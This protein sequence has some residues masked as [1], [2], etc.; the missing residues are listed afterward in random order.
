[1]MFQNGLH[2]AEEQFKNF[3]AGYNYNKNTNGKRISVGV[4]YTSGVD[5]SVLLDIASKFKDMLNYELR[6]LY[7]GYGDLLYAK[8]A[9]DIALKKAEQ[10]GCKITMQ[11]CN[12]K[13]HSPTFLDSVHEVSTN[14]LFKSEE[15]DL[16]L[17]PDTTD[18]MVETFLLRLLHGSKP[19]GLSGSTFLTT[20]NSDGNKRVIGR[21]F[22][23]IERS[24]ILDYARSNPVEFLTCEEL[25]SMESTDIT[26]IRNNIMPMINHRFNLRGFVESTTAIRALIDEVSQPELVIDVK[27]GDWSV[28]DFLNLSIGNRMFLIR[29]YFKTVHQVELPARV[30][31]DIRA[32]LQEDLTDLC[33]PIM[34]K[35]VIHKQDDRIRV[36]I[37]KEV[38][39]TV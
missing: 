35:F 14:L 30:V 18:T 23:G 26:Y 4:L 17:M 8:E 13:S 10:Y 15:L 19:A 22:L 7:L 9:D 25:H 29:E 5:S 39:V 1:M 36:A 34:S 3:I 31:T 2:L 33:I 38:S 37:T 20:Y 16:I 27:S 6:I 28:G 21:P 24:V 11:V 12:T 32:K